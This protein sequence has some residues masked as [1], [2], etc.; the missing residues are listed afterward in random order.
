MI[1]SIKITQ[2]SRYAIRCKDCLVE[3]PSCGNSASI[4]K[5]WNTRAVPA[6]AGVPDEDKLLD[7]IAEL[8]ANGWEYGTHPKEKA[9][10]VLNAL[11]PYLR[12]PD[13]KVVEARQIIHDL[14][15]IA[16]NS[17]GRH[18]LDARDQALK[19]LKDMGE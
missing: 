1:S 6:P 9:G 19:W 2:Q 17:T 7:I 13:A 11:K 14:L 4:E 18:V 5:Q 10:I 12:Q 8:Q 16:Q 3:T 15:I